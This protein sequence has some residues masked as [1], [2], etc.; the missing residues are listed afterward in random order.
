MKRSSKQTF[1]RQ[2]KNLPNNRSNILCLVI[3]ACQLT[4]SG[5]QL[6]NPQNNYDTSIN[7]PIISKISYM[8]Y[9][10]SI[11]TLTN[12]QLSDE[13][14]NNQAISNESNYRSNSLAIESQLKSVLFYALP[15]SKLHNPYTA[16]TTL[17]H[18][19]PN[20]LEIQGLTVTDI[21]FF[22]MLKTQLNQQIILL[23]KLS[24]AKKL[25]QDTEQVLLKQQLELKQLQQ[26]IIQLKNIESNINEHGQ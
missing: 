18:F 3:C 2:R 6:L 16:K 8:Q 13:I 14:Q 11:I 17:N 20:D 21:T 26:Q 24:N 25:K 23:N 22:N 12:E 19:S 10:Q 9:Y 1:N 15:H 5:C 4:L 7:E